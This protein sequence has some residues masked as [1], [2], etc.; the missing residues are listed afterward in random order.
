MNFQ[1]FDLFSVFSQVKVA[2]KESY[3]AEEQDELIEKAITNLG[4]SQSEFK[5]NVI[6]D[7]YDQDINIPLK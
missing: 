5:E 7:P 4:K 3:S 1:E 2:N 6:F